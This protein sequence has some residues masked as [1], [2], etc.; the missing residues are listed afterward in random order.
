MANAMTRRHHVG[1]WKKKARRLRGIARIVA[2]RLKLWLVETWT[3]RM[4]RKLALSVIMRIIHIRVFL[5]G[6]M[7]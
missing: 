7:F 3:R 5:Y 6:D 4:L 2:K 1:G